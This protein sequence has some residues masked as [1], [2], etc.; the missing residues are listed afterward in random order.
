MLID[1]KLFNNTED[2]CYVGVFRSQV[3]TQQNIWYLGNIVMNQFY[4]VFDASPYHTQN[5]DFFQV[6]IA[7]RNPVNLIGDKV[8]G[9][10]TSHHKSKGGD[11]FLE[12]L[13]MVVGSLMI[14]ITVAAVSRKFCCKGE[15]KKLDLYK[16]RMYSDI[17]EEDLDKQGGNGINE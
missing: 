8:F 4:M 5:L 9:D 3:E 14:L 6:G 11:E 1:G 12:V 17:E 10:N 2:T 15:G 16:E 7:P 13:I